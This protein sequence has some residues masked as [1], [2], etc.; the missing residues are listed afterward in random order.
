MAYSTEIDIKASSGKS[1]AICFLKLYFRKK[2]V[3]SVGVNAF[4][5][6]PELLGTMM[7]EAYL[8][9]RRDAKETFEK[10]Q[11]KSFGSGS[12]KRDKHNKA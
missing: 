12:D 7:R 4:K 6:K 1:K 10:K 2:W 8:Q 9:G 5:N 11:R 3:S